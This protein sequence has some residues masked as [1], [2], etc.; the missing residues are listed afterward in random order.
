MSCK[1]LYST[2]LILFVLFLYSAPALGKQADHRA[3]LALLP[4]EQIAEQDISPLRRGLKNMIISRLAKRAEIKIISLCLSCPLP[5]DSNAMAKRAQ[6]FMKE[7]NTDYLLAGKLTEGKDH[8]VVETTI[9][10]R[11]VDKPIHIFSQEFAN[12]DLLGAV[13]KISWDIAEKIFGSHK[14]A[15]REKK[16]APSQPMPEPEPLAPSFQSAHP[17]RTLKKR[18]IIKDLPEL[19]PIKPYK[20]FDLP[21]AAELTR[22]PVQPQHLQEETISTPGEE[23]KSIPAEITTSN[24]AETSNTKKI[25]QAMQTMDIGDL[26]GDGRLD[27]VISENN[28]LTAYHLE[29]ADLHEFAI[30]PRKASGQIISIQLADLNK[31]GREEIYASCI[32]DGIADS[33]GIEWSGEKFTYLFKNEKWFVTPFNMPGKGIILAGQ[34]SGKNNL[35]IPGIFRLKIIS[36]VIQQR[37]KIGTGS[38]NLYNFALADLDGNGSNEIIVLEQNHNLVIKNEAGRL[39]QSSET[40]GDT[41]SVKINTDKFIE[42]PARII[43]ADINNDKLPEIIVKQN[44][45]ADSND[46]DEPDDFL[47][48]SIQAFSWDGSS[49]NKIWQSEA[50]EGYIGGYRFFPASKTHPAQLYAGVVTRAGILDFFSS[51]DSLILIY[52]VIFK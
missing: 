52:P 45:S 7:Y 44:M 28:R 49:L 10:A 13:D 3:S 4:L 46:I 21:P 23:S 15:Y 30:Q 5:A 51:R 18:A 26:D 34:Q 9:Y 20:S 19:P 1:N 33:F 47:R 43:I 11:G 36:Q 38:T 24:Q 40:F 17:D 16:P 6:K 8:F 25:D 22:S 31:N 39:W 14:P 27:V 37:E 42:I 29:N 2:V 32:V 50:V 12:D 41:I 48:G 35:F